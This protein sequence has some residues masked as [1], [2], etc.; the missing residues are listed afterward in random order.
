MRPSIVLTLFAPL[1]LAQTKPTT[2]QMAG[3]CA[4]NIAG[5]GNTASLVCKDLDPKLAS[6]VKAILNSTRHN[7]KALANVSKQ[8]ATIQATLDRPTLVIQQHSEGQNSPN[9]VNIN[10]RPPAR[11]IPPETRATVVSILAAHPAKIHVSAIV[12]N[13]EAYKF[14]KDWYDVFKEARWTMADDVVRSFIILGQPE[15]GIILNFHGEPMAPNRTALVPAESPAGA[16]LRA[17]TVLKLSGETHGQRSLDNP[18]G[19]FSFQVYEQLE[20]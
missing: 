3:D 15:R 18:E 2:V 20:N 19:E 6:Q 1:L 8:L 16:I 14:A 17:I 11:R 10:Q 4:V 5:N 9:T 12:N 7:E 13:P